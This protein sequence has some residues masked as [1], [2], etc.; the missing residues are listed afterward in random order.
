MG[1]VRRKEVVFYFTRQF[2]DTWWYG[3][4]IDDG[5]PSSLHSV[6]SLVH[7]C[8]MKASLAWSF[9]IFHVRRLPGRPETVPLL[10]KGGERKFLKISG[11]CLASTS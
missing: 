8:S 11:I 3:L 9:S 5:S 4:V 7:V 1:E 10:Q 2:V 6:D